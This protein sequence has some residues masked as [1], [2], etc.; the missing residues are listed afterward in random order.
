M[1]A[2]TTLSKRSLARFLNQ[3]MMLMQT[4]GLVAPWED[5]SPEKEVGRGYAWEPENEARSITRY[6]D[7]DV[8]FTLLDEED[9]GAQLAERAGEKLDLFELMAQW[10]REDDDEDVALMRELQEEVMSLRRRSS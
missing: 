4:A 8:L 7:V 3:Q 10:E 6:I 5:R 1:N 2:N 9:V